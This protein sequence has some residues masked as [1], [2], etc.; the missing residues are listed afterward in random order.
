MAKIIGFVQLK[1]G[2]GRSTL[3]TNLAGILAETSKVA[4]IDC[5]SP[6]HTCSHWLK[7]RRNLYDIDEVLD[8]YQPPTYR[9]L[10]KQVNDLDSD[11]DYIVIDCPPRLGGFSRTS[12]LLANLVL[13]P[14]GGSAAEI[15]SV[16]EMLSVLD[17]AKEHNP[18]LDARIIWN[19]FRSYTRS[20]AENAQ[21]AKKD[22]KLPEMRQKLGLRVAY[23]EA[24]ADGL[25]VHETNDKNARVE[26]WSLSSSIQRLMAKQKTPAKISPEKIL[27]FAKKH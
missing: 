22:L 18:Q 7:R 21:M 26:L 5:D 25:T 1:G 6:Q 4:L 15:W 13:L 11:Y 12:L 17:D 8:I 23:A 27:T 14:L 24:M 19:R 9:A 16:E 20:A 2:V 10:L 3:A